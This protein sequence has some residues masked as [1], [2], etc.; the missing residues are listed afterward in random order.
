[1]ADQV[2]VLLLSMIEMPAVPLAF[3]INQHLL[4]A[5]QHDVDALVVDG[6]QAHISG[7]H[8]FGPSVMQL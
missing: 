6:T 7:R 3:Y 4:C 1:M 5:L 2:V 8:L